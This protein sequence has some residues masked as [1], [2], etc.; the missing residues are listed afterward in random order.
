MRWPS[1]RGDRRGAVTAIAAGSL[2]AS[3]GC[4]AFAVDLGSVY[5]ETRRLQGIADAAALSAAAQ[6]DTPFAAADATVRLNGWKQPYT[7]TV[8]P[9]I[10]R[11]DPKIPVDDRFTDATTGA[12]AARVT[13]TSE[14]PLYF[15][16]ALGRKSTRISRSATAARA[17][18]ASFSIGSRL[19]ALQGGLANAL[20]GALTGSSINLSVMDYD[21]LLDTDVDLLTFTDAL[22]TRLHLE[23]ASYDEVLAADM[24]TGDVIQALASALDADGSASAGS[25]LRKLAGSLTGTADVTLG[26]LIDLGPIGAQDH[27]ASGQA[28]RVNAFDMLRTTLGLANGDRQVQLD[29][30]ATV[31]GLT[32]VT[33]TLAIGDR[34]ATSPWVTV[35]AKG[36]P[37]IRTAQT[38]LYLDAR[39]LPAGNLLGIASVRLPLFIE[40]AEAEAKLSAIDCKARK[41]QSVSLL[42]RPAP[43][44]VSIADIDTADLSNHK[45]AVAERPAKIVTLPLITVAGQ[46][47]VDLSNQDWQ[48]VS[49]DS[50]DIAGHRLK[51]VSSGSLVQ[52]IAGSLVRNLDLS[53]KVGGLSIGTGPV[54]ALVG[55]SLGV[56]A[57][58]L[59]TLVNAL[60][61]LLGIHI[62]QADV[63]VNGVRCGVPALVA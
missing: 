57:P 8:R 27:A 7:L 18:L 46:A 59:D 16:L 44:H 43:G 15:A 17:N 56:A 54:G 31:P 45:T 1:L 23:A 51:T 37:V 21:A 36:E 30:G 35:T 22:A 28:I 63:R 29:L 12:D 9:G 14:A 3:I 20:L 40:L 39:V 50:T 53:V 5:F 47:R 38:R 61:G 26:S 34:M 33:A 24:T 32:N 58:A 60:T 25:A 10:Y 52:G 41:P 2:L 4:L 48:G 49:F 19:L 11:P 42:V 55:N 13:I 62:G 6:L